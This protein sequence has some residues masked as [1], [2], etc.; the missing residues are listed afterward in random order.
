MR[1]HV[2]FAVAAVAL[3]LFAGATPAV[4]VPSQVGQP[5]AA[6]EIDATDARA[7]APSGGTTVLGTQATTTDTPDVVVEGFD[8]AYDPGEVLD[9]VE[10][11]RGLSAVDTV[12]LHEYA[13]RNLSPSDLRDRFGGIYPAGAAALQLYSNASAEQRAP[14][15]YTVQRDDGVHV[16]LMNASDL[17]TYGIGQEVVLAHELTHALQFQQDLISPTRSHFRGEFA[18]W[19]TDAQLVSLALVEGDAMWVTEQYLDRYAADSDYSVEGYNRTLSR[20]AWPHSVGGLPYYYGYEFYAATDASPE[21]RSA[22]IRSPPNATAELLTSGDIAGRAPLPE[23]PEVTDSE[24]VT[25]YHTDTVGELVIR[26]ALRVNGQSFASAAAAADGW[27]NDRMYY[28][29]LSGTD[30]RSESSA[31]ERSERTADE[32]GQETRRLGGGGTT[33]VGTHWVSVWENESEA[34]EFASA[35][36]E[37]LTDLGATDTGGTLVVPASESAPAVV[38]VVERDGATVRVTAADSAAS[39]RE[40]A[41]ATEN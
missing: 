22:A 28:Y 30:E 5:E 41:D 16:Y 35:W 40:I 20:A 38:Y 11:L 36:R 19:T 7:T 32:T 13:D 3:V 37:M 26:H 34:A 33:G 1:R 10:R 15:G 9:R 21:A 14:L 29:A 18:R 31:D 23:S 24:R 27:E 12:T 25:Q 8:P 17:R 4:G 2:R 6:G 39:A